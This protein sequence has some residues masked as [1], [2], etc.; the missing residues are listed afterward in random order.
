MTSTLKQFK[1]RALVQP[2]VKKAYDALED[3]FSRIDEVLNARTAS[4]LMHT[5]LAG[6]VKAPRHRKDSS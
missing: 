1:A 5:E 6:R 4:G 3:E 2:D